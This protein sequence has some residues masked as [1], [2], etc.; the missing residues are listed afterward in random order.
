MGL[1]LKAPLALRAQAHGSLG[2]LARIHMDGIPLEL[3][4]SLL[5]SRSRFSPGLLLH[6]HLGTRLLYAHGTAG[7]VPRVL[8]R[9]ALSR[10]AYLM[11]PG[12]SSALK[13]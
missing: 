6:L 11:V 2:D 8:W 7:L 5:P 12:G 9:Y 3:A 13:A 1:R 4:T 10:P